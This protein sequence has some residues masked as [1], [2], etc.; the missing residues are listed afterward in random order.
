MKRYLAVLL[1]VLLLM[2]SVLPVSAA[3]DYND[4]EFNWGEYACTHSTTKLVEAVEST[5]TT[6]G[7][8]A[9]TRCTACGLVLSGSDAELPL[10]D[11]TYVPLSANPATCD[12]DGFECFYCIHC[13]DSYTVTIP[14]TGHDYK[15]VVTV[16][17]CENS[18]Y[19]VHTC[20][21]CG[22]TYADSR[23]DA[24]GHNY[25]LTENVAPTCVA[26][27]KKVYVCQACGDSYADVVPATGDH[28]YEPP[29][30][31]EACKVC[32]YVRDDAHAY[33]H[34]GTI[35]PTCGEDGAHGYKCWECGKQEYVIIPATGN[36]KYSG[37]C[38]SECNVCGQHRED[39]TQHDYRLTAT[40]EVTCTT[41]GKN[42]YTCAGCK[43]TYS[44]VIVAQ[45]HNYRIVVTA[46]TCEQG[47][48][49]THTC[50]VCGDVCVD[51][52][53]PATGHDYKAVV[54][55]PDCVNGGYTTYTCATCGDSYVADET[56]ATDHTYVPLSANPATCDQDGFECFYCIHCNDS[57]TVT[58][59]ATGH[60]YKSVVTAPDCENSGYTVHTCTACG[61][62]YADS[63]V[64]ALGHD[65][66][67]TEHVT[68]T[69][70]DA[71][72]KVYVCNTCGDTYTEALS[73]TGLHDYD[74]ECDEYCNVCGY[75][76][77]D[78]HNYIAHYFED[79]TCGE[80]GCEIYKCWGL[81]CGNPYLYITIPATGNHTYSG[82]CDVTC[83][84]CKQD[85]EPVASHTYVLTEDVVVTCT[86][87]GKQVF[88][89]RGCGDK[90]TETIVAQGHNYRIVVTPPTCEQGGYTTHTCSACGDVCV[91]NR[92]AATGHTYEASVIAPDCINFGY[93]LYTCA[94]CGDNYVADYVAAL[95]H[96]YDDDGDADCNRCGAIR[97][98][99]TATPGDANG[100]GA[101][102]NRDM[103]LL[104]QYINKWDV[105][106]DVDAM[107]VNDDGVVNNRDLALI[108]Q[109]INKWDVVLK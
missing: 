62:T 106:I 76:R 78:A 70:V 67:M 9:Y 79:P 39:V 85:R 41:D 2:T 22:D 19:T 97:E 42:T 20:T 77:D 88:T 71:G 65:Y 29:T 4:D 80:D 53:V 5:C 107:D 23:V 12:Q 24:L 75:W 89:C 92:T 18:G 33:T 8:D 31:G 14:A 59:P 60:D 46:P 72:K 56:A 66:T 58:I 69:C 108:Q 100:D 68:P 102:N 15:S 64:D 40:V 50:S 51:N 105:T 11:H 35:E 104:Q 93:T 37:A 10:G 1:S 26:T 34:M 43:D 101:V 7:H 103:A 84:V 48:Y 96:L 36:H 95:D 83:N 47:G 91:D 74:Y 54:T 6:P 94:A 55:A 61:D 28:F 81:F 13:N 44:D 99:A 49:T 87:D 17:N 57:Y 82:E 32:G 90:Y 38:D 109:Y 27:G 21:A 45:G 63:R 52:R 25:V 3:N 98:V 30:C 16:P 86:T 73:A